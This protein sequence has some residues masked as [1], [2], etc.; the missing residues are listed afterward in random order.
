MTTPETFEIGG[1]QDDV[2]EQIAADEQM[3]TAMAADI[4][5]SVTITVPPGINVGSASGSQDVQ[6]GSGAL[7]QE[8]VIE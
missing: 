2:D 4:D 7:V 1:I 5:G 6:H 3:A 8:M